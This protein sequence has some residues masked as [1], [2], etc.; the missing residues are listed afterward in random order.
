MPRTPTNH[1]VRHR[2][3]RWILECDCNS[4]GTCDACAIQK[5][6]TLGEAKDVL[7]FVN[8]FFKA[9]LEAL[10]AK[11]DGFNLQG[12][13]DTFTREHHKD[14]WRRKISLST[15]RRYVQIARDKNDAVPFLSFADLPVPGRK[16][17]LGK[18]EEGLYQHILSTNLK[19]IPPSAGEVEDKSTVETEVAVERV[20]TSKSGSSIRCATESRTG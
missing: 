6:R 11:D 19:K 15:F 1:L 20:K 12:W 2:K 10:L 7:F 18:L 9:E 16:P 3:T 13:Y 14:K 8:S 4:D 5:Y 17:V